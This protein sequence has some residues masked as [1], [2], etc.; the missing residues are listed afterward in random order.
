MARKLALGQSAG[1][2]A[3]QQLTVDLPQKAPDVQRVIDVLKA[4]EQFQTIPNEN[5][6]RP[7]LIRL[8]PCSEG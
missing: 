6:N 1:D 8:I 7:K 5:Q 4:L 2:S 3:W